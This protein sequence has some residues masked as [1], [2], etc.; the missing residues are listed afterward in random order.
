[1]TGIRFGTA[2]LYGVVDK[3]K[4]VEDCIAVGQRREHDS[5]ER[6]LL[7]LKL[8]QKPMS[9]ELEQRIRTAIRTELSA[10]HVPSY[11]LEVADIPYTANGKKIENV[12]KDV[13]SGRVP[14]I[15][16][17]AV[18]PECLEEYKAFAKLPPLPAKAR[19]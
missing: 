19:L 15:G 5:D 6:V 14:K 1:M 11:I 17:T 12:V 16:G 18:N 8:A 3:F 4:E 10:R 7:F 2:E 9:K 13:V